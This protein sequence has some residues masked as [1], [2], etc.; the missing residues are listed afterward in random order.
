VMTFGVVLFTLLGQG[1]TISGVLRH[2]KLGRPIGPVTDQQRQQALLYATQ[3]GKRELDRLF[4]EGIISA[5]IW[6]AMA[7]IYEEEIQEGNQQLRRHLLEHPELELDM[8]LQAREDTLRAE[9][10]AI[11]ELFR[12]G[13][14]TSEIYD[15][16]VRLT[17]NRRAALDFII[18]E[19]RA[20]LE[21][22]R[23]DD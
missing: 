22:L 19:R 10:T 14:V 1:T 9:R 12:R 7:D 5:N 8:I 4:D 15:E 18:S 21:P 23:D 3:S 17:D 20:L 2:L 11:A 6:Q 13:L 16:L